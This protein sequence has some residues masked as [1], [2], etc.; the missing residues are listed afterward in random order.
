MFPFASFTFAFAR[1]GRFALLV[2]LLISF[3]ILARFE[4]TCRLVSNSCEIGRNIHIFMDTNS[5]MASKENQNE[6]SL[7]SD[8]RHWRRRHRAPRATRQASNLKDKRIAETA[9]VSL[10]PRDLMDKHIQT[11]ETAAKTCQ[12]M[13][14]QRQVHQGGYVFLQLWKMVASASSQGP[15]GFIEMSKRFSGVDLTLGGGIAWNWCS[16]LESIAS[17]V[18]PH[19]FQEPH[20]QNIDWSIPALT[21]HKVLGNLLGRCHLSASL[22]CST[23]ESVL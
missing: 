6:K 17:C 12:N 19:Q 21:P 2:H 14:K 20:T 9:G 13:L 15:H 3:L 4:V 10:E 5:F 23:M 7:D 11:L 1:P 18:P 16:W 22:P 8:W